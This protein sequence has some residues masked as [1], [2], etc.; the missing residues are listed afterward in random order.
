VRTAPAIVW[1]R[2]DLRLFDNPALS[3]AAASGAPLIALYV[4]D[5]PAMGAWRHGA[6]SRWRLHHSLASLARDLASR[7]VELVLRRGAADLALAGLIEQTGATAVYWNRLYEPWAVRRDGE[8]KTRLRERGLRVES[9]NASL[10]FEPATLDKAYR[11]FT[12]FWRACLAAPGPATP[13]STPERLVAVENVASERLEDW[14]LLPTKPDWAAGFRDIWRVGESAARERLEGFAESSAANYGAARDAPGQEGVSRL[15]P[16]L[17]FGEISPRQVWHE[18]VARVGEHGTP[19]LRQLGWR[20][21]CHH[22]LFAN[23]DLPE[24]P[25]DRRFERFPWRCDAEGFDAWKKG[26]TGY[27]FVDAA[28]RQLWR[29][30]YTH[31]RARMVAASFLVKHLLLPWQE[32]EAWFWDTLVD[33][34]LANNACGWQWVA[35]CGADA[36]PY[37]RVFN[38]VLQGEKFDPEG[39]YVR[40]YVPEL[41]TLDAKFIH[42]PWEAPQE[43]LR[44]AGV[45]LGETYPRPIVDHAF[46]RKRALE[47]YAACR[48]S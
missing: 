46:A 35:G 42:R 8:I 22:L 47:A 4:L 33:A 40:R 9:F 28:M 12:P 21:F 32:G 6:A 3:A 25:L 26:R 43:V 23:P 39:A 16:H 48:E 27:P 29:T 38:P 13:L 18:I 24:R 7:G 36:A 15:S 11:V 17:H 2:H 30:G 10:L 44:A 19:F 37:F 14:R 5:E 20:E 1:F 41:A 31:N 34:D 45:A